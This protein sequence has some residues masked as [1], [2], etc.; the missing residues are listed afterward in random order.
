MGLGW[1]LD[2]S[3]RRSHEAI[4]LRYGAISRT[5]GEFGSRVRRFAKLLTVEGLSRG[6]RLGIA[7][8]NRP[9][10]I[11]AMWGCFHAGFCAVPVNARATPEEAARILNDA[12][13]RAIIHDGAHL[14]HGMTTANR[15]TNRVLLLDV[16]RNG[17]EFFEGELEG[18]PLVDVAPSDPALLLYTSG[19]TG[20]MKGATLSHRNLLHMSLAYLGD[21]YSLDSTDVVLHV[22]P[23]T[24]GSGL[25]AIPPVARGC[26]QIISDMSSFSPEETLRAV[27]R[28][29][30][31]V[32]AFLV[33][34]M[35]RRLTETQ[36]MLGVDTSSLRCVVYGGA[37]AYV[38]DLEDALD[39]FGPVLAQ[40]YGQ[41][42]APVT[43]TRLG[44]GDHAKFRR[45][46]DARLGSVGISYVG[47]AVRIV[48]DEGVA[49]P[50][51]EIGEV[52]VKGDVVMSGYW[53]DPE[54][55]EASFINGWLKTGDLG[56]IDNEEW[57]FLVDRQKDVIISGGANVYPREIE[58]ILITHSSVREAAVVGA[59]DPDWGE[60]IVAVVV[61]TADD[62]DRGGLQHELEILCRER[63]A[64]YKCPRVWEWTDALPKNAY[65]KVLKRDLRN[66]YWEGV[67]RLI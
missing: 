38:A 53:E 3:T 52:V 66:K 17:A 21:V 2:S 34:T 35:L 37:P 63:L 36:R 18:G 49:L 55:T 57:L 54:A 8:G 64:G 11:E 59:P 9:E 5:Y 30:V 26:L 28:D 32:I 29:R 50:Y 58:E 12:T 24:H 45:E 6:D 15:A 62:I 4:A 31:T 65:G 14:A 47:T 60:R 61:P 23:L 41:A 20:R 51:G 48:D 42:E 10:L 22:A 19:T 56:Y 39:V 27:E 43:I 67:G 46:D 44:F 25:Y 13:V 16:D 33:P 40:I 1:L 7:M